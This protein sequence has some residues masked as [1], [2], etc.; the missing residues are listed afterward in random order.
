MNDLSFSRNGLLFLWRGNMASLPISK[1]RQVLIIEMST[2][3]LG[4]YLL[5]IIL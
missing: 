5:L 1:T 2:D 4:D 3:P